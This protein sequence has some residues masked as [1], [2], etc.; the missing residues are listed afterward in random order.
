MDTVVSFGVASSSSCW[1]RV[2]PSVGR[3]TQYI[4][5]F[6]PSH[7]M[8]SSPMTSIW[9]PPENPTVPHSLFSSSSGVPLSWKKAAGGDIV[10]WFGFEL[11]RSSP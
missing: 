10:S 3:L 5:G 8:C 9:R 6:E 1:S 2:A 4:S 11:L 7:G